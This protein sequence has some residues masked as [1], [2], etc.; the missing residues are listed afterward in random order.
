MIKMEQ[1][2]ICKAKHQITGKWVTGYYID[3]RKIKCSKL[4]F[5]V[6]ID[7][8][9]HSKTVND[10]I[11][12]PIQ[13]NTLCKKIENTAWFKKGKYQYAIECWQYDKIKFKDKQHNEHV[14]Y[15]DIKNDNLFLISE[16]LPQGKMLLSDL[17]K[18][19]IAYINEM[20]YIDA[21][22]LGSIFD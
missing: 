17:P 18:K 6:I 19:S 16:S 3:F 9:F 20:T 22:Y 8:F 1:Q 12:T 7:M 11:F 21:E 13:I 2:M 15:I 5:P 14:G 10:K 4:D